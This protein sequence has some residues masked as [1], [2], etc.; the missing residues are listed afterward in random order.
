M[1]TGADVRD[2]PALREW[3]AAIHHRRLVAAHASVEA[4]VA[5]VGPR[6]RRIE[7]ERVAADVRR[8]IFLEAQ[9][10]H[11]VTTVATMDRLVKRERRTSRLRPTFHAPPGNNSLWLAS[12]GLRLGV[13][14]ACEAIHSPRQPICRPGPRQ[15]WATEAADVTRRMG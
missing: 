9:T 7:R 3:L 1:S 11:P 2:I 15:A 14:G 4:V 13:R 5:D 6:C 8:G 12:R 10:L